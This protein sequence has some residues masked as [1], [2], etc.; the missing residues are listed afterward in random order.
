MHR[1]CQPMPSGSPS[2]AP[3]LPVLAAIERDL[4]DQAFVVVGIHSPKFP[5]QRDPELV[6]AAIRR[7]GVTH[8][9]V[10]DP[11]SS[12]TPS[13]AVTGWPTMILVGPDGSILGTIRGEP[14]PQALLRTLGGV[15]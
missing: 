14:E 7:L 2:C 6:A 5:A 8:P 11:A 1:R 10:L 9:Q 15:M 3:R 12:I 13:F 4:D